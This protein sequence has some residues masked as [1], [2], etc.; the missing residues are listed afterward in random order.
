MGRTSQWFR[1]AERPPTVDLRGGK[2][3]EDSFSR[4]MTNLTVAY[5]VDSRADFFTGAAPVLAVSSEDFG[6]LLCPILR[7]ERNR[8]EKEGRSAYCG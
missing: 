2:A 5:K 4:L 1:M 3:S 6:R 8:S 7:T